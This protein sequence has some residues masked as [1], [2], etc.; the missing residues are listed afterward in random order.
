MSEFIEHKTTVGDK[1]R[2]RQK[3]T[4]TPKK[5]ICLGFVIFKNPKS[6]YKYLE[7]KLI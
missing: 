1:K 2:V 5:I 4:F 3:I 7:R 6:Y